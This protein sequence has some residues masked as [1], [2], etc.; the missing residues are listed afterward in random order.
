MKKTLVLCLLFVFMVACGKQSKKSSGG[1]TNNLGRVIDALQEGNFSAEEKNLGNN[2]CNLLKNKRENAVTSFGG[3]F[4]KKFKF[5][6]TR[7]ECTGETTEAAGQTLIYVNNAGTPAYSAPSGGVT[8]IVETELSGSYAVYCAK[9]DSNSRV[10]MNN[11]EAN[12]YHF[13]PGT[14]CGGDSSQICAVHEK[15]DTNLTTIGIKRYLISSG[16][17]LG[18][19]MPGQ[20]VFSEEE[21]VCGGSTQLLRMILRTVTN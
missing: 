2:F 21:I 10:I 16:V 1:A 5:D 4:P 7:K 14:S 20:E 17:F 12:V 11:G 19:N 6:V 18:L 9:K 3:N 13:F 8:P 15:T